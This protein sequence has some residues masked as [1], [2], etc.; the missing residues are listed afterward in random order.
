[1]IL[2]D[3]KDAIDAL[4][5]SKWLQEQGFKHDQDYIWYQQGRER[6]VVFICN[7]AKIETLIGLKFK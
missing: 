2:L 3:G 7:D 5:I 4:K 1:M 6:Q